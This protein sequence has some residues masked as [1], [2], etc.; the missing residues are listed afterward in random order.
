MTEG[1]YQGPGKRSGFGFKGVG[2]GMAYNRPSS[3]ERKGIEVPG[4]VKPGIDYGSVAGSG[5]KFIG[6]G[7]LNLY[8]D[9]RITWPFTPTV[10]GTNIRIGAGSVN[11]M[12]IA[13]YEGSINQGYYKAVIQTDGT[14]VTGGQIQPGSP[15]PQ[16]PT[17]DIAPTSVE[18]AIAEVLPIP[19]SNPT[20]YYVR[21]LSGAGGISMIIYAAGSVSNVGCGS[22]TKYAWAV[23]T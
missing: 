8:R 19:N 11:G 3:G 21:R 10:N 1:S 6:Q 14:I 7:I 5:A 22:S 4:F 12:P 13:T 20:R 15:S 16:V 23:F 17:E 2:Q 18:V 9:P